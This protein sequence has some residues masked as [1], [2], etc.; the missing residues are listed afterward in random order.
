MAMADDAALLH[1]LKAFWPLR[2]LAALTEV[3]EMS[4]KDALPFL[5]KSAKTFPELIEKAAFL[6][7]SRP[8]V[9]DEKAAEAILIRYPVVY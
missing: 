5:K 2:A 9:P 8:V 4:M 3:Q 7:V 1:E 6:M